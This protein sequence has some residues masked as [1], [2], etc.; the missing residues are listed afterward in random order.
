MKILGIFNGVGKTTGNIYTVLHVAKEFEAY[1]KENARGLATESV[2][3]PTKIDLDVGDEIELVYAKGFG[4]K[5]IVKDVKV[6]TK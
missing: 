3:I 2:Y 5:A 4:G 6:L 1:Q